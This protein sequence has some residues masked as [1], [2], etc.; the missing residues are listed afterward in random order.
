[1]NFSNASQ[2]SIFFSKDNQHNNK[3]ILPP[4]QEICHNSNYTWNNYQET[5]GQLAMCQSFH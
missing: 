3:M 4:I 2:V 1:M 5:K